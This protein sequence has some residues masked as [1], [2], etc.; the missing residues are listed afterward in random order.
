[1][2]ETFTDNSRVPLLNFIHDT[3]IQL[4]ASASHHKPRITYNKY[5]SVYKMNRGDHITVEIDLQRETIRNSTNVKIQAKDKL[6]ELIT[7]HSVTPYYIDRKQYQDFIR[8]L[9][10]ML[11]EKEKIEDL[12]TIP[13]EVFAMINTLYG[14][15][16]RIYLSTIIRPSRLLS[17]KVK[18]TYWIMMLMLHIFRL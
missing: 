13:K 14:I 8:I 5:E 6:Y 17:L 3:T 12:A 18:D 11:L 16:C 1:M 9:E 10:F 4:I 15:D 7:E 2:V